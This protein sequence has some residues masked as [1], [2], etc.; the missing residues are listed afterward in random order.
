MS[1][2]PLKKSLK[3]IKEKLFRSQFLENK[4]DKLKK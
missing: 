2:T 4:K 3:T 1:C